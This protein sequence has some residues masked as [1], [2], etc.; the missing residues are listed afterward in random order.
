MVNLKRAIKVNC[1]TQVNS[2]ILN[3]ADIYLITKPNSPFTYT[4]VN[5][6]VNSF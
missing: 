3:A 6:D 1:I 5:K 2:Q 4:Y